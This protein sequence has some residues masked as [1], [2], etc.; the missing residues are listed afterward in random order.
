MEKQDKIYYSII[1]YSQSP[2]P[3]YCSQGDD[4]GEDF[5][6]EKLNALFAEAFKNQSV[7]VVTLDGADGYASSFLDE[8]FGNLVYDFGAEIVKKYLK[9]ISNDEDIWSTM[10]FEET[11]P[12]WEKRRKNKEHAK[13]TQT[14][15]AWFRVVNGELKKENWIK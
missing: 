8:A 5:Y 13:I 11:L 10:I 15:D 14:H 7:L 9:I 6:H 12:E 4:S 1:D 2:G 3:R